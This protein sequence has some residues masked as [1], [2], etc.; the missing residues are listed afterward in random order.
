MGKIYADFIIINL[1]NFDP[2]SELDLKFYS[3]LL[4]K[5]SDKKYYIRI[6]IDVMH[7]IC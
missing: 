6:G 4:S 5:L 2:V 3:H 1:Y 7:K